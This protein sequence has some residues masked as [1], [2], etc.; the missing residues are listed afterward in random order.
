M[1]ANSFKFKWNSFEA[2]KLREVKVCIETGI[3]IQELHRATTK[4]VAEADQETYTKN[5]AQA[6]FEAKGGEDDLIRSLSAKGFLKHRKHVLWLSCMSA[7]KHLCHRKS[8]NWWKNTR[9][10]APS[11]SH[12]ICTRLQLCL[13]KLRRRSRMLNNNAMPIV[14]LWAASSAL[15]S[16][17]RFCF[18][19]KCT[20]N[21][22]AAIAPKVPKTK[23]SMPR[24]M[25]TK[26]LGEWSNLRVAYFSDGLK[27][28]TSYCFWWFKFHF[29]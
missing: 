21:P 24:P 10:L 9:R 19:S 29:L 4:L 27:P 28:P 20:I 11:K 2:S 15:T 6:C 12:K 17:L 18:T 8:K 3:S 25:I 26:Y 23:V 5:L 16:R 14:Q 22:K 13:E 7:A 1:Q